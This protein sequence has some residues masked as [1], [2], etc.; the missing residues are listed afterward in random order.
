MNGRRLIKLVGLA[1]LAALMVAG[2][3]AAQDN[4]TV[5]EKHKEVH[6]TPSG[7]TVTER[8][9]TVTAQPADDP[10]APPSTVQNKTVTHRDENGD[11]T[12][13]THVQQSQDAN[14]NTTTVQRT[15]QTP[16]AQ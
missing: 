4:N 11:V 14:G 12:R 6:A 1:P 16:P 13:R 9:T 3:A 8:S 5:V 10:N 15:E 7:G 2:A